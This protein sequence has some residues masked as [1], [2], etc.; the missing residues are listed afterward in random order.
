MKTPMLEPF[1]PHPVR[2]AEL[3]ANDP[4]QQ[5]ASSYMDFFRSPG[6]EDF[7]TLDFL[8]NEFTEFLNE[9][10]VELYRAAWSQD[11]AI[12]GGLNW[13]R[14][15][16]LTPSFIEEM[17]APLSPTI[18]IPV[19]VMWGLDD[20]AVLSS[21]AQGLDTFCSDLSVEYFEGVD[22]WIEH[23]IPSAVADTIRELDEKAQ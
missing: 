15:N 22:H 16:D 2:F 5:A 14:A 20:D 4:D 3:I 8:E 17:M 10:E 13:Y 23:R 6:A 7:I 9:D 21:N 18:S 12:T 19:Q 1:F 11:G